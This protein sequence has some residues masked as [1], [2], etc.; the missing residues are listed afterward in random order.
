MSEAGMF[1]KIPMKE[2]KQFAINR[3]DFLPE[4]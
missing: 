2:P 1:Y 4:V 3:K